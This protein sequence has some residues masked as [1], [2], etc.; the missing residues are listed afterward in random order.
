MR[1]YFVPTIAIAMIVP[2]I[3]SARSDDVLTL[4]V[5]PICRGIASQS[6]DPLGAGLSVTIKECLQS[7]QQ[8]REQLKKA[9]SSF[10]TA[11]KQHC[12]ALAKTGG[13]SSYTELLSC[14]EMSRDVRAL[15]STEAASAK[16]ARTRTPSSPTAEPA[17]AVSASRPFST[18]EPSNV[19]V[20]STL[21]KELQQAKTDAL[22]ARTSEAASRRKLADAEAELKRAKEEAGRATKEAEQAKADA[23]AAREA[24]AEAERKVAD[25]EAA[26][27]A[28]EERQRASES[29][30]RNEPGGSTWLPSWLPSWLRSWFG[31]W[32]KHKPSNP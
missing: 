20:D 12:V 8:V 32:F 13:E 23:K 11:D 14:L 19:G 24:K 1:R 17:P 25:A 29:A 21:L 30:A 22:D 7:E 10:S 4:D 28:A 26:Q 2:A 16:P 5:G 9:W 3:F 31:S 6:A 27:T 18:N 15:K